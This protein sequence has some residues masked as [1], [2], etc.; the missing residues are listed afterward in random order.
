MRYGHYDDSLR[1]FSRQHGI[2]PFMALRPPHHVSAVTAARICLRDPPT[3]LDRVFQG[4]GGAYP[5]AP[6]LR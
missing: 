2:S 1:G 3:R 4:P 5:S 6:P